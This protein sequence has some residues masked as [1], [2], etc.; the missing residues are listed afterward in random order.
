MLLHKTTTLSIA[1][2]IALLHQIDAQ[3]QNT[4]W[5]FGQNGAINFNN[6]P[7]GSPAGC[8]IQTPEGSASIADPTT[9]NLLFYTD[10]ITVWDA[11]DQPM[12]N[13][14]GLSGGT[15]ILLSSTKAAVI[16]PTPF[17]PGLFYLVTIDEQ[18][19]NKGIRYSLVDMSLNGGLGDVVATQKNLFLYA[20]T[21]EKLHV[22]P[23][24]GGCDY[25]LLTHDNPGNTFVAF[26]LT[27]D[28]FQASTV[29]STLGGV[30]G[31][32]AGHL[33]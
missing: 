10:G 9:G 16:I 23:A 33:K 30:Q 20:T 5:R 15:P 1:F 18:S 21:S 12:P 13:G 28:G 3:N 17:S 26:K 11:N 4:Q 32:G 31:N 7:P 2:F 29:L 25:W 22:V 27:Q 6:N 8:A 24:A 19:S 14:N